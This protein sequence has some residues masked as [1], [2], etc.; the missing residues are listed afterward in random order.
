MIIKKTL[1]SL[2][3]LVAATAAMAQL[4]INWGKDSPVRK[5]QIA[6]MA[7]TNLYVD[8]VNEQNLVE[9]G[10][11]GMLEKLDPHSAYTS[12]QET[13][14]MNEPLQG[15]F[16]GIG[17][18]FNM[19]ED[20]LVV[21]QPVV[22]G[23]SEKVGIRAGDR[24]I[25]VN[26]TAIAGVK[27]PRN[28]IMN[29]LRG[30]RGTRVRLKIVRRGVSSPLEFTVTRDKIPLNTVDAVYMIRPG[31]GYIRL[32]SFG[33]TSDKEIAN[34]LDTLQR[35]GMKSLI[36]DLQDNG[37]GYLQAAVGIASQF[38]PKDD[39]I[40]YTK[41]RVA[42][43]EEFKSDGKGKM[44]NGKL[45]ILVNEFTASAAEIVTG[46]M[47]DQDRGIIVGR[48]T[49]GKGLVQRPI[50]FDDG[51]MIR[52]TV[53][54][55][56]TPS[57]RCIQKPYE[58]GD[59]KDYEM[60][61]DNRYKHGELLH[62]DS[63]H[64]DKSQKYYTLGK[65]RLVYGGG[66]I[67][68]DY[69]VPLDTTKFTDFHRK[70]LS[71]SIAINADLKYVDVHRKELKAKYPSFNAFYKKYEVPEELIDEI[72]SE[73]KKQK[74]V[75]KDEAEL[76]RTLPYLKMQLKALIARDLWDMSQYYQII[77]ESDD[78]VKKALEILEK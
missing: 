72:I 18:Q 73:G 61:L 55:Y 35:Q 38:L 4:R 16:D 21:I 54:H 30:K 53:A 59:L 28:E 71:K 19:I 68:P 27:M 32:S 10:I 43:R 45:V 36:F 17:V 29:R 75:P 77:N 31:I 64:L 49:F 60:D 78:T 8:S 63:I 42:P 70:L 69:F 22:N 51:S 47:Q 1:L 39:L 56:Y 46:A 6:E 14:E 9:N 50:P 2:L 57:G 3:F 20:T 24:I 5:L 40:V 48:R 62:E 66:G 37:G 76:D 33:M 25:S 13:K 11:R 52:L 26:D 15:N 74:V 12:A 67:M 41:G 7:I 44:E 65:H 23:P 34:A 58:K